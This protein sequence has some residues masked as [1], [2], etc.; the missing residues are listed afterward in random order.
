[1]ES[2]NAQQP[3]DTVTLNARSSEVEYG[4]TKNLGNYQSERLSLRLYS[5]IGETPDQLLPLAKK[6]VAD[7]LSV[8]PQEMDETHYALAQKKREL[9]AMDNKVKNLVG[10]WQSLKNGLAKLGWTLPNDPEDLPF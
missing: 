5:D 2:T 3:I 8:S 7:N 10:V 9:D 1:V 4:F 6:W